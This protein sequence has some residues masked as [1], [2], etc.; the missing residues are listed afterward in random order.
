MNTQRDIEVFS[1]QKTYKTFRGPEKGLFKVGTVEMIELST[2]STD[3]TSQ[4]NVLRHDGDTLGVNGAQIGVFEQ[5]DQVGLASFLQRH[6]GGAL[7]TQVG[8]E[9]LGDLTYQ[10]LERQFADQ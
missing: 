6:D 5:T 10:A 8:L 3:A 9:V 1:N 2:F 4:L 7:E